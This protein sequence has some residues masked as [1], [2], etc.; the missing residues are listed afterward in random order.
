MHDGARVVW[1]T[2]PIQAKKGKNRAILSKTLKLKGKSWFEK[3]S[4]EG[5]IPSSASIISRWKSVLYG[6]SAACEK[7]AEICQLRPVG[8]LVCHF[9]QYPDAALLDGA[10]PLFG[11]RLGERRASSDN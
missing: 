2:S 9:C 3:P 1:K 11:N 7:L 10:A 6:K 8:A 4:F 5:S